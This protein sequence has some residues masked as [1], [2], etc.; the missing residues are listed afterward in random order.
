MSRL[1]PHQTDDNGFR[2]T[3]TGNAVQLYLF[4]PGE[5]A[6]EVGG[7]RLTGFPV[8]LFSIETIEQLAAEHLSGAVAAVIQINPDDDAGVRAFE[9]LAASTDRALLAAMYE[10]PLAR[11]RELH[12]AGAHDVVPLPL[13]KADLER[14]LAPVRAAHEAAR[15]QRA[16]RASRLICTIRSEGGI[17]AT[18]LTTQLAT[19][20][21]EKRA[22]QGLDACLIDFDLQ[23][24]DAA[25]Q[26]G[27]SPKL[28]IADLIAAGA[29]ADGDLL[30][31]IA[32]RH[33]SGLQVIAAP[34]DIT[35]L[36]TLSPERALML[37][38]LA[39]REFGTV[40]LDL[41]SNWTDW[42]LSLLARADLV[43]LMTELNVSS[44]NRARRQLDLIQSQDLGTLDLRVVVNRFEKGLFKL[45]DQS[46]LERVLGRPADYLVHREDE[47]MKETIEQGIPMRDVRR[48]ST[49][50]KDL[51]K[52]AES[53]A[54]ILAREG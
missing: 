7:G 31:T 35:P 32:K 42:S 19:R 17:G 18:A 14:S 30:R 1:D 37:A 53:L 41:P 15:E 40:F 5:A 9:K 4:D 38:Q 26:L 22:A 49:L 13:D 45:V 6:G 21:A 47:T 24:G 8:E 50:G 52:M 3:V 23:F 48:R 54:D 2:S 43:L 12:R 33:A 34:R 44:L 39:M 25:F 10:P 29:R 27:L 51:D 36:D 16:G 20:Y 28:T 46:D 11:V